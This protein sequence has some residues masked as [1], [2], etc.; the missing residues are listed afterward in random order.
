MRCTNGGTFAYT[1]FIRYASC[2]SPCMLLFS[3]VHSLHLTS[4]TT[5]TLSQVTILRTMRAGLQAKGVEFRFGTRVDRLVLGEDDVNDEDVNDATSSSSCSNGDAGW[6][7][8]KRVTGVEVSYL[9]TPAT[10]TTKEKK[11]ENGVS[12]LATAV[13]SES[14]RIREVVHADHVVRY[15]FF[16]IKKRLRALFLVLLFPLLILHLD[17]YLINL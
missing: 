4:P 11:N 12:A 3:N 14:G 10:T 9:P 15:Y 13:D 17:V 7:A 16:E 8:S 1:N 6:K 5:V 2:Y